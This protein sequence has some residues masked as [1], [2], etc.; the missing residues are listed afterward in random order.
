MRNFNVKNSVS[1]KEW[2][3]RIELAACARLVD[4]FGLDDFCYGH[5]FARCPINPD[6]ILV[7]AFGISF[8]EIRA[9]DFIKIDY[10]GNVLLNPHNDLSYSKGILQFLPIMEHRKDVGCLIHTHP[11]YGTAVSML[12]CGLMP[13]SQTAMRFLDIPTHEFPGITIGFEDSELMVRDLAHHEALILKNHG[14]LTV[15]KDIAQAFNAMYF[16]EKACDFQVKAMSCNSAL[17]IPKR[18]LI[19]KSYRFF[20]PVKRQKIKNGI[21]MGAREWGALKRGLDARDESYKL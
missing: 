16:L 11:P 21:E 5:V 12:E 6:Q 15:G 19:E 4:K 14:V 8:E 3:V 10:Q 7:P 1:I 2:N 20:D 9:S 18:E 13:Y 17:S